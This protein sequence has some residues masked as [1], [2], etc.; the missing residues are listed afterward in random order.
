MIWSPIWLP[1]HLVVDLVVVDAV[2]FSKVKSYV[3]VMTVE[4]EPFIIVE[5]VALL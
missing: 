4:N 1:G 5:L 2:T 3:S